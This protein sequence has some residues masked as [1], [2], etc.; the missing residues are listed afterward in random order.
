MGLEA[1]NCV[2]KLKKKNKLNMALILQQAL[3]K[4]TSLQELM[5]LDKKEFLELWNSYQL[6]CEAEDAMGDPT[7]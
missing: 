5:S 2:M 7:P 1:R 4:P 3:T 6:H